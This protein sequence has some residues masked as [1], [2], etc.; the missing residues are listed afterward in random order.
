MREL[1]GVKVHI[2]HA[3]F[4][5][6]FGTHP[7]F[8]NAEPDFHMLSPSFPRGIAGHAKQYGREACERQA[9]WQEWLPAHVALAR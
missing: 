3:M 4:L 5:A 8:H 1:D 2:I 7:V 9:M 6:V